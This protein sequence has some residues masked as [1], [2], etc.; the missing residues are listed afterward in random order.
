MSNDPPAGAPVKYRDLSDIVGTWVE[1]PV[2]DAALAE[3]RRIEPAP[4]RG[5]Y[6]S[7]H[8]MAPIERDDVPPVA[9]KILNEGRSWTWPEI[10]ARLELLPEKFEIIAGRLF[11]SEEE[12]RALLAML[13][14]NLGADEAVRLAPPEIWRAALDRLS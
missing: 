1:D 3:Q 7:L 9:W 6:R 10:E 4:P 12:R 8:D 5:G 13:L 2:V 11:W 14:E